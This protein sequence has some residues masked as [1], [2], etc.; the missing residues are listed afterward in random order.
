MLDRVNRTSQAER[1]LLVG[2]PAIVH[3]GA[4]LYHA[5]E[6]LGLNTIL[7]DVRE[8]FAGP[9]WLARFNWRVLG[10]RPTG[11]RAFSARVVQ[12]CRDFQPQWLVATGIAPLDKPALE[13]IGRLGVLRLNYLTDDPWNPTHRAPWFL[14]SLALYDAI[15]SPRGANLDDL[16]RAGC[17]RVRYLPFAYA[18]EVHFP[19]AAP[20]A[21][22]SQVPDIAFVGGGD[23]DRIPYVK[24][25][26][27]SGESVGLFGGY[28]ERFRETRRCAR[29]H[30]SLAAV[31]W[32]T[33]NAGVSLCL[34]RRANRDGHVMRSFEIP[35][36]RGCMLA[37]DTDEHRA[38]FGA[39]DQAVLYFRTPAEMVDKARWLLAR[40]GERL[41]L[42]DACHSLIRGGAN[43]YADRL[44]AMLQLGTPQAARPTSVAAP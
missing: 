41:R 38:F 3:I 23:Q 18:P 34:V 42:A 20:I 44:S 14:D 13:E 2:N 40:P 28:W 8:A 27:D 32:I 37:E 22:E 12:A 21:Q 19:E 5:A 4:H 35:A 15:F 39:D 16:E 33:G 9:P 26:I 7:C 25:L 1:L 11:L 36:M 31:R 30:A 17:P 6:S 24:A 29:G 43:T 10:R